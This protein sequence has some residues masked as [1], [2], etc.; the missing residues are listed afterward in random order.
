MR[1]TVPLTKMTEFEIAEIIRA[2]GIVNASV[3]VREDIDTDSLVDFPGRKQGLHSLFS[4]HKQV[5]S[6]L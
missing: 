4:G 5:R 3:T 2:Y 6:A 1:S